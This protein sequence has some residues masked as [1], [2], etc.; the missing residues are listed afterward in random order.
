[1]M[2]GFAAGA[3]LMIEMGEPAQRPSK[4]LTVR[5]TFQICG[6]IWP[7]NCV[8]DGDTIR[9][10]GESIRLED[11]NAPETHK[12]S[13]AAEK[14][15][16]DRATRRLTQLMNEGPFELV[17]N[18]GDNKDKYGRKLR[19]LERNGRSLGDILVAEG[20]ARRWVGYRRSW[21]G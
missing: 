4:N 10:N 11:I 8:I 17:H 3:W 15:L 20:L 14:A 5:V 19:I 13:C 16:G 18:G 21:C 1:M 12:S 6:Q 2:L 7:R 9:Y